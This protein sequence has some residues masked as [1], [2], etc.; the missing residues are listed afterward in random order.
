[1]SDG[2][3]VTIGDGRDADAIT[4]RPARTDE[5]GAVAELAGATFPLAC[6]P[7]SDPA[8]I[9][10]F[11]AANL[12]P[13]QFAAHLADPGHPVLVADHDGALVGYTLLILGE[14][15]EPAVAA[16]LSDPT[17]MAYLS[18]CYLRPDQHGH[19]LAGRLMAATLAEARAAGARGVCLGV[20]GENARAQA[21][22]RRSGFEVTG[23]RTF[24]VGDQTHHDQV[25]TLT[26]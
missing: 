11:V 8:D 16:T 20:N 3:T 1:M 12:G 26:F 23:R 10:D 6:P 2:G 18:K 15:L 22:Y 25:L 5:A 24:R 17:G 13:E 21:F 9:A 14:D 19:G 4:I 7:G